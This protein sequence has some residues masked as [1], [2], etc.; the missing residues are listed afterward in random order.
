MPETLDPVDQQELKKRAI[1]RLAVAAILIVA[2]VLILSVLTRT[3]PPAQP[4]PQIAESG[5]IPGSA[6]AV[7]TAKPDDDVTPE[8][9]LAPRARPEVNDGEIA[10]P[11]NASP[12]PG[13]VDRPPP[14]APRVTNPSVATAEKKI[15]Q[16]PAPT[17]KAEP[18]RQAASPAAPVR[19]PAP[20]PAPSGS[21]HGPYLVQAGVFS[22]MD[23]ARH[24][25]EQLARHGINSTTETRVHIGPFE[26]RQEAQRAAEQLKALGVGAV[27]T[28]R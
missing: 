1:R 18:Q 11:P 15:E 3:P 6:P 17:P 5:E 28:S 21:G 14:P 22:N 27:V 24:L 10:P 9:D 4:A 23:N 13:Q 16:G 25:Q 8:T 7:P 2:A 12:D 26:S 20:L 19:P